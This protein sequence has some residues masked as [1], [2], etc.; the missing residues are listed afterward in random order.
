MYTWL[1]T[2]TAPQEQEGFFTNDTQLGFD[3]LLFKL[4]AFSK[5]RAQARAFF[6]GDIVEVC[7]E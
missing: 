6:S 2:N 7:E 1:V 5:S 4:K 3:E